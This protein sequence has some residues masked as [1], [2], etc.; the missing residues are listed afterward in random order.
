MKTALAGAA[1]LLTAALFAACGSDG[2]A[3]ATDPAAPRPSAGRPTAVPAAPGPVHTAGLVTVMDT[4]TPE[5]CLGPVAESYPPQ[6]SGPEL[7]G[8]DWGDHDGMFE[9]QGDVR[10]GQF[11]LTGT[12]DG[13]RLTSTQAVPAPLYD[14]LPVEGPAYPAPAARLDGAELEV[15]RGEVADLPGAQGAYVDG[16]RVLVDVTYDDGTLQ[17]WA[18]TT[19]GESVVVVHSMLVS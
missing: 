4:G 12:W 15:V 10:W 13:K 2:D 17:D 14:A 6:C 19:Y 11:A 5:V 1:L 8:W 9:E 7:L 18:D 3:T 16:P